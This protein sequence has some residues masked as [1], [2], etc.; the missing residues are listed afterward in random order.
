MT[1]RL[2][3]RARKGRRRLVSD[4]AVPAGTSSDPE[5]AGDNPVWAAVAQLAPMQRAVMALRYLDDLS[6][7]EIGADD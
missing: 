5:P 3:L 2:A 1:V 4:T 6:M 7:E